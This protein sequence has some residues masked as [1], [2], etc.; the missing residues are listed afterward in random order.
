M[1]REQALLW[2]QT[3]KDWIDP[4]EIPEWIIQICIGALLELKE[5]EEN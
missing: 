3:N 1:G 5:R 4:Y 2:L